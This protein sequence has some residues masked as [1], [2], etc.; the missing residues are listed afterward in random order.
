MECAP[1]ESMRRGI[2]FGILDWERIDLM[3]LANFQSAPLGRFLWGASEIIAEVVE[4]RLEVG[5]KVVA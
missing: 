1:L 5:D 2:F 4:P 3:R